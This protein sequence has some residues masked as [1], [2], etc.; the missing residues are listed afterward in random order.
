MVAAAAP[1]DSVPV[2]TSTT[3]TGTAP[4]DTTA[5]TPTGSLVTPPAA[6]VVNTG[7][8]SAL[9]TSGATVNGAVD[10]EDLP[11]VYWIEYGPTTAY[12]ARSAPA[13]A[14]AGALTLS[15][16]AVLT[17]LPPDTT[18]HYRV[19]AANADGTAAGSDATFT[20]AAPP[21]VLSHPTI[22]GDTGSVS[23]A[24][25]AAIKGAC[26]GATTCSGSI[27][28]THDGVTIGTSSSFEIAPHGA[29]TLQIA[30]D[31]YG[32]KLLMANPAGSRPRSRFSTGI[33][34]SRTGASRSRLTGR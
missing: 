34:R 17:D 8:A 2:S 14:G 30:V 7:A 27:T 16:S 26:V 24:G 29:K 33:S 18:F 4:T 15:I 3:Q 19:V 13:S 11:T 31:A 10:A 6:P 5:T 28:V 25:S 9:T 22:V 12:G 23:L 21:P 20:T 1:A 32:R